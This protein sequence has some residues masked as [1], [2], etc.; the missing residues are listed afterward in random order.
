MQKIALFPFYWLKIIFKRLKNIALHRSTA[1]AEEKN[2]PMLENIGM[3]CSFWTF[4]VIVV[5]VCYFLGI[6]I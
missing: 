5:A 6:E 2:A 1:E 3:F 4:A